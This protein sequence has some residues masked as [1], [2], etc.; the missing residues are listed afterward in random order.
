MPNAGGKGRKNRGKAPRRPGKRKARRTDAPTHRRTAKAKPKPG[1]AATAIN[2][3]TAKAGR[4]PARAKLPPAGE[5]IGPIIAGLVERYPEARCSLDHV[6]P[7]QLLVATILSAQ[8]TDVR[9]NIVTK[10]LF[11]K[12]RTADDYATADPAVFEAEIKSTGF[13]RNKTKSVLGMAAA[14]VEKFGGKVPDTMDDLLTLPG[15]GRKTANVVLG[16]AFGKDEGVVV[17]T[18]V[19]RIGALLA[20]TR[21]TDPVKIEQ[22]LMAL[23][24][25]SQWTLFPHLLIH[26]GRATCIARRP[27]CGECPVAGL[28]PSAAI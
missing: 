18:H 20:L 21:E 5:R 9:V 28:C 14:L 1:R 7:L 19:A 4:S 26:H 24:P 17:D 13:F 23:V 2:A 25:R 3:K 27:K 6:D 10:T 12:Y 11:L 16:N 15:V 8:C 22:D